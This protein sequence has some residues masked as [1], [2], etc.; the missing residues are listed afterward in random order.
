MRNGSATHICRGTGKVR[1]ERKMAPT[2]ARGRGGSKDIAVRRR[3]PEASV[4]PCVIIGAEPGSETLFATRLPF[5]SRGGPRGLRATI[6]RK[7][8]RVASSVVVI[9]NMT[10]ATIRMQLPVGGKRGTAGL[11]SRV[12]R[13]RGWR[14]VTRITRRWSHLQRGRGGKGNGHCEHD[15]TLGPCTFPPYFRGV[16]FPP[17]FLYR[18]D[19]KRE[20]EKGERARPPKRHNSHTDLQLRRTHCTHMSLNF[21]PFKFL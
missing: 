19:G 16:L 14:V 8:G 12:N 18:H 5:R 3:T 13:G 20:K 2:R 1:K 15:P 17:F 7:Q 9:R 21:H 4:R 10:P 6:H 11:L